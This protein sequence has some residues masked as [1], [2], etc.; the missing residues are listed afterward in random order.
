MASFNDFVQNLLKSTNPQGGLFTGDVGSF[1]NTGDAAAYYADPFR[2]QK[3]INAAKAATADLSQALQATQ[4]VSSGDGGGGMLGGTG[5]SETTGIGKGNMTDAINA[6]ALDA[7]LGGITNLG[8]GMLGLIAGIVDA[9]Q[10]TN[11]ANQGVLGA[12]NTAADPIAAL[13]AVQGWTA[14]D[15]GQPG[16]GMM[17]NTVSFDGPAYGG[18]TAADAAAGLSALGIGEGATTGLAD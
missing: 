6:Q 7:V 13:N 10:Q 1:Y 17:G 16:W 3:E 11:A 9:A 5:Q 12:V 4:P 15:P 2:K 8:P 18:N 14:Q